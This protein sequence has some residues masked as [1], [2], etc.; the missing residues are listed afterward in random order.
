M[1]KNLWRE[2]TENLGMLASE[3]YGVIY[4]KAIQSLKN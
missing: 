1:G 2:K 4:I 3:I